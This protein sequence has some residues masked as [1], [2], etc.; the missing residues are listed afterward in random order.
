MSL[1]DRLNI[2]LPTLFN[3]LAEPYIILL[4]ACPIVSHVEYSE[5]LVLSDI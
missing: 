1:P 3:V 2:L 4:K 5:S